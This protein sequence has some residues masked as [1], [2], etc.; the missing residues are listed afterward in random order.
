VS[1]PS[2]LTY[3]SLQNDAER[4]GAIV[5]EKENIF[6]CVWADWAYFWE[7]AAGL[8]ASNVVFNCV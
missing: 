1:K 5:K 4:E 8:P 6:P 3:L 2:P 7:E